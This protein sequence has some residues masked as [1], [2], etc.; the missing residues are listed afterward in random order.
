M[1]I[2]RE[3]VKAHS[4]KRLGNGLSQGNGIFTVERKFEFDVNEALFTLLRGV[5]FLL[6]RSKNKKNL[7]ESLKKIFFVTKWFVACLSV[8]KFPPQNNFHFFPGER[9]YTFS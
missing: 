6:K 2:R 8:C 7:C 1:Q 3:G 4:L 5:W 9:N